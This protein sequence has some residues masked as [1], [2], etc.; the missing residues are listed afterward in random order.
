MKLS[1]YPLLNIRR[2]KRYC[3]QY[4]NVVY[5]FAFI[6]K[7]SNLSLKDSDAFEIHSK[8]SPCIRIKSTSKIGFLA[9]T[10]E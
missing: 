7:C 3:L 2:R 9:I 6:Q 1:Q 8:V 5:Y 10:I 4:V